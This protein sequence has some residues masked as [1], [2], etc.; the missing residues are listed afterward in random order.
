MYT[1]VDKAIVALVMAIIGIIG[2]VYKPFNVSPDVVAT[3]VGILTP[4]LVYFFPNLPK[5]TPPNA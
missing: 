4:I 3:F 2:V 5:D 1:T